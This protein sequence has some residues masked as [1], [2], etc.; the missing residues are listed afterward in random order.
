M[1]DTPFFLHEALVDAHAAS[2][3]AFSLSSKEV[4]KVSEEG[5]TYVGPN[6]SIFF[7][8]CLK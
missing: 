4:R 3:T 7:A 8:I 6:S 2:T 1:S 5:G